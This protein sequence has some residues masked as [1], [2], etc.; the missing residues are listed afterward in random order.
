MSNIKETRP[1]RKRKTKKK[2]KVC[3]RIDDLCLWFSLTLAI[4]E[5]GACLIE[6]KQ[7]ANIAL[8]SYF[9]VLVI[10]FATMLKEADLICEL[11]AIYRAER[12]EK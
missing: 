9:V 10:W 12:R 3:K 1:V 7:W 8:C 4:I 6:A 2:I 5:F 11:K